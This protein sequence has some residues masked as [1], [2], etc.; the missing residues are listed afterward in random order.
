[1]MR[2]VPRARRK[3]IVGLASLASFACAGRART[4]A[5]AAPR[6]DAVHP[7]TVDARS[8]AV[9][10]VVITG[11]GFAPGRPGAN[12][13]EVAGA[14]ITA[15]PANDNGTELRFVVPDVAS[16]SSEAPPQRILS[17]TYSLRVITAAG[18]SNAARI[19]VLR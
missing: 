19:T 8:G 14:R 10:E 7:D 17:G 4:E 15:V 11:R 9:I 1:M 12:T 2:P 3:A 13:L 18:T 6:I 5:S 16:S